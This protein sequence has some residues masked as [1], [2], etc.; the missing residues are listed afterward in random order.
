MGCLW[1]A[2]SEISYK[3]IMR[4]KQKVSEYMAVSV[5]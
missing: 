3:V 5:T 4:Y 1:C 2:E